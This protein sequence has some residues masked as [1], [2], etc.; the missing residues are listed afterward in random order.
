MNGH[1]G[2][3]RVVLAA[4]LVGILTP[5]A[6]SAQAWNYP[7][8]QPPTITVREFNFALADG[9]DFG[10]SFV[11]QWREGVGARTQLGLELGF[12][13]PDFGDDSYL[14]IGGSFAYQM[15]R[16]SAD[17]PLDVL[18]ASGLHYAS[19]DAFDVIRVPIGVSL[20]H[21]FPLEGQLAITPYVH[22][23]LQL[24]FCGD[25]GE[26]SEFGLGFDLGANFEFSPALAMR[27]ALVFGGS[28]YFDDES[29]F[30]LSLAWHP[31][32]R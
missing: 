13:D 16:A 17:M 30:G 25:C 2:R 7:A 8:F 28:D 5:G 19:G 9:G 3:I 21:R 18:L 12:A 10:T 6:A 11:A 22:P 27:L 1:G 23:K 31:G 32:R 20:G 26:D 29:A 24:D 4:V 15:V 14:L